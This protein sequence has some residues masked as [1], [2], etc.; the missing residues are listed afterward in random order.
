MIYDGT[1]K[2]NGLWPAFLTYL[3]YFTPN[4]ADCSSFFSVFFVFLPANG[5]RFADSKRQAYGPSSQT[6]YGHSRN[7][8]VLLIQTVNGYTQRLVFKEDQLFLQG[9]LDSGVLELMVASDGL[10][11]R[12]WLSE[13]RTSIY[14]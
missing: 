1:H 2:Y 3:T 7:R 8:S 14:F 12:R 6:K 13:D 11:C 5:L 4:T 10:L 9:N